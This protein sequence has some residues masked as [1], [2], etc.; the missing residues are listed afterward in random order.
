MTKLTPALRAKRYRAGLNRIIRQHTKTSNAPLAKCD[1]CK[2]AVDRLNR[3]LDS[4]TR[5]TF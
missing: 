3:C 2:V 1:A 5:F 4:N